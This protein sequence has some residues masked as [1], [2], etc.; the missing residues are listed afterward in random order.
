MSDDFLWGAATASYQIEGAVNEDRRG[1]SIWNRF[2]LR[3]RPTRDFELQ[4]MTPIRCPGGS[5][6]ADNALQP[7]GPGPTRLRGTVRSA[8]LSLLS[9]VRLRVV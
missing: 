3:F 4:E 6:A 1:E 9:P 8:S 2:D 5:A 7:R